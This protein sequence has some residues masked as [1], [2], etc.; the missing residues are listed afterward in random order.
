MPKA[1][2]PKTVVMLAFAGAQVLDVVGP[3]QILAGVN[4]ERQENEPAYVL[5]LLARKR[6]P[7]MTSGGIQ[8][9]AD[10]AYAALPKKIDTLMIAGG[11]IETALRDRALLKALREGAKR[12]RRVV[13]ICSGA[14]FLAATGMLNGKRA[15]THWRAV[16]ALA[17]NFPEIAVERDALFVR[18]GKIWT[19]AGVTAGMDL[20]LALV[21]ED[22][23][24]AMA[25]A[26]A[27]RHV[28]YLMRP[29]GQSQFSA[30]LAPE[31]FSHGKL[32]S[33]LR[34]IPE[35]LGDDL[36]VEALATRA[37]MSARNFA[38]TFVNET[39]DTP[40]RYVERAR[41]DA[42]RRMLTGSALPVT[43]VAARAGFGSEERMRRAF[44]RQLKIGP[45]AFRARF[46]PQGD[47]A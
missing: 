45:A 17:R 26:V 14:F 34:W 38:R 8:L 1:L 30:H 39:G 3:I 12:A 22:F 6:G 19:S 40:A 25:L 32:S 23:G 24:D 33:L 44:R 42:A 31:E 18:E 35:H 7:F 2:K 41:L 5:T 29:G 20:A 10:G 47:I 13:S 27:R 4:D 16:D 21:R 15:T 43:A 9:V 28:M 11:N 36:D 46:Q 37:H